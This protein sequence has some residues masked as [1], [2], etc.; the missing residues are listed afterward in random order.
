M[1]TTTVDC[2]LPTFLTVHGSGF[3]TGLQSAG[4]FYLSAPAYWITPELQ[5][6]AAAAAAGVEQPYATASTLFPVND[7]QFVFQIFYQGRG[8]YDE[9]VPIGVTVVTGKGRSAWTSTS[10][11][12]TGVTIASVPPPVIDSVSGCPVNGADGLSVALCLP[13]LSVLTLTGSGFLQWQFS[14]LSL[15]IG[16]VRTSLYLTLPRSSGP[17]NYIQ[18]DTVMT[19]VLDNAYRYLLA[20]HDFGAPPQPLYIVERLSGWQSRQMSIQ[21]DVLPAPIVN[22][23][24]PNVFYSLPGLPGCVWGANRSS[25]VNCTA[26]YAGIQMS[27]HYLYDVV[28][29]IGGQP[30]T[31]MLRAQQDVKLLSLVTPLYNF[32]PGVLYDLVLTA[33]SGSI[34]MP[35]YVSFAGKPTIVSAACRDPLLPIDIAYTI[36]CQKGETVTMNGPYL[37]PPGTAFTVTVQSWQLQQNFTCLNPRYNSEYQL[38]CEMSVDGTTTSGYDTL[39]AAR[40]HR[41]FSTNCAAVPPH[42]VLTDRLLLTCCVFVLLRFLE[43]QNGVT[44]TIAGRYGVWDDPVAPR[45]R[46]I[47]VVGGCGSPLMSGNVTLTGCQGGELLQLYG[48]NFLSQPFAMIIQARTAD[49]TAVLQTYTPTALCGE[50]TVLSD[51]AATCVLPRVVDSEALQYD[52]SMMM[53]MW[54]GTVDRFGMRSNALFF[55]IAS[56]GSSLVDDQSSSSPSLALLV[57]LPVALAVLGVV[58]VAATVRQLRR[59]ATRRGPTSEPT[60]SDMY[61]QD[62]MEQKVEEQKQAGSGGAGGG[63]W[64]SRPQPMLSSHTVT[65][66]MELIESY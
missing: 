54:N 15:V 9:G 47:T 11:S 24:L 56:S 17:Y 25:M 51:T 61:G 40:P 12:F 29:T 41:S 5:L 31:T 2:V 14:P 19:V 13:E 38:A 48:T 30:M 35:Q 42:S 44:I 39:S 20:A 3:L 60:G 32:V 21:F 66:D 33:A 22:S 4:S 6:G 49:T 28:A 36:G 34:T 45:I 55:T 52:A 7:T 57:A 18:N 58:L 10:A 27:G 23:Y 62:V 59:K 26:G 65:S 63:W 37:P 64:Q 8:V 16:S 1:G 43:W 50:F 46:N 53:L